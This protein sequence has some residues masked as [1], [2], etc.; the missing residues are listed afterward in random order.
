MIKKNRLLFNFYLRFDYL[1]EI[2][3]K[4]FEFPIIIVSYGIRTA[5]ISPNCLIL[6]Y[7]HTKG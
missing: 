7:C 5:I 4:L 6:F 1:I 2:D 3:F